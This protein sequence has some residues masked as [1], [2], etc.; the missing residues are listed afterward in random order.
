MS[1]YDFIE[2]ATGGFSCAVYD[3]RKQEEIFRGDSD[4]LMREIMCGDIP[5][6]EIES[7]DFEMCE[8]T[9]NVESDEDED[10]DEEG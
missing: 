1:I 2:L 9:F 6:Y 10:E 5:D 8:I 4:D 3:M 7:F